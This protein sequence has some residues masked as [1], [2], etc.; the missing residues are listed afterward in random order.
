[1]NKWQIICSVALVA[2]VVLVMAHKQAVMDGRAMADAI[3]RQLDS[4]SA[5]I[6]TLL[7]TMKTNDTASVEDAAFLE[8]QYG[9]STSLIT[10]SDIHVARA[11]DGSLQC[12]I[13]TSCCGVSPRTIP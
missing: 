7:V 2:I 6:A 11:S 9:N 12:V 4:H 8:M 5:A 10:R 13:D 3:T 1:M